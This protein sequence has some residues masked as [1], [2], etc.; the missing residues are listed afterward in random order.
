MFDLVFVLDLSSKSISTQNESCR[1]F[2][3]LQLLFWPKFMFPYEKLSFGWSKLGQNSLKPTV[4]SL[5]VTVSAPIPRRPPATPRVARAGDPHHPRC[6]ALIRSRALEASRPHLFSFLAT[7]SSQ[8]RARASSDRRRRR[9]RPPSPSRLDPVRRNLHRRTP[10]PR[11]PSP[12]PITPLPCRIGLPDHGP[13]L[14]SAPELRPS[15]RRP[16][17]DLLPLKSSRW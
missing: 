9:F 13:P 4:V 14:P 12:S 11:R 6:V 8:A 3:P 10:H 16:L 7:S 2:I 1:S 17:S 5:F 15:R